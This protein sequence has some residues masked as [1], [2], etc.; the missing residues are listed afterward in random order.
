MLRNP[1][2]SLPISFPSQS[3]GVSRPVVFLQND[4]VTAEKVRLQCVWAEL[5]EG[6]ARVAESAQMIASAK[7]E[8]DADPVCVCS[9]TPEVIERDLVY[10]VNSPIARSA[11]T[12]LGIRQ[13]VRTA[14][15]SS[16][17]TDPACS[18]PTQ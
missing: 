4:D 1:S 11:C 17:K 10:F 12:S 7:N 18:E 2:V 13:A 15:S 14:S 5:G 6:N 8:I 16:A 9:G 3:A